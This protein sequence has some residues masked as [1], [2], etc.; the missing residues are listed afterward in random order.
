MNLRNLTLALAASGTALILTATPSLA[1]KQ[2][3]CSSI[4]AICL[5]R[6]PGNEGICQSM[7]QTALAQGYW[8]ATTEPNG[9]QHPAAPCTK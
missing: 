1:A 2:T 8:Q 9:T 6:A 4:L 7:Y 5:Q 3:K